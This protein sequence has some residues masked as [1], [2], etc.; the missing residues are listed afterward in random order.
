MERTGPGGDVDV[1]AALRYG[2]GRGRRPA[3]LHRASGSPT[4]A[5]M[6]SAGTSLGRHPSLC[7]AGDSRAAAAL[8]SAGPDR[9]RSLDRGALRRGARHLRR[10]VPG[11]DPIF[12][13]PLRF[14]L[15]DLPFYRDLLALVLALGRVPSLIHWLTARAWSLRNDIDRLRQ[16]DI[17][18]RISRSV[19]RSAALPIRTRSAAVLFLVALA[20]HFLPLALRVAVQRTR[21]SDRHGLGG[22]ARA[23][24]AAMAA[25]RRVSAIGG[26]CRPSAGGCGWASS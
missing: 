21:L 8:D 2:A 14:Y 18:L 15:F 7:E 26:R 4:P 16:G 5:G 20:A 19:G 1:D 24:A 23:P 10:P 17:Q 13:H 3:A 25:D 11:A 12:G 6:K 9:Y 22:R